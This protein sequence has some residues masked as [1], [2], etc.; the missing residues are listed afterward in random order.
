MDSYV[1]DIDLGTINTAAVVCCGGVFENVEMDNKKVLPSFVE[2]LNNN[3]T[4]VG[5][6]AQRSY[7]QRN[8][9]VVS[10]SKRI[11]GRKFNCKEVQDMKNYCGVEIVSRDNK[12]FFKIPSQNKE[13]SPEQIAKIILKKVIQCSYAQTQ[14]QLKGISVSIPAQFDNNQTTATIQAV[15][16]AIGELK[17]TMPISDGLQVF[18]LREPTAAAYRYF[19]DNQMTKSNILVYDFGGGTFDV[20]IIHIENKEVTVLKTRGNNHLGGNDIDACI[21][22]YYLQKYKEIFKVDCIPDDF[23]D[24]KKQAMYRQIMSTVEQTKRVLSESKET[25]VEFIN[26]NDLVDDDDSE[27]ETTYSF[28]LKRDEFD[29]LIKSVIQQ[30]VQCVYDCL[31]DAHLA[32]NDIDMVVLAGGS[33]NIKL[34]NTIISGIFGENKIRHTVDTALCVA[35]GGCRWLYDQYENQSKTNDVTPY[36]LET[37]IKGERT[38]CIIPKGVPIPCEYKQNFT[39]DYDYEPIIQSSLV[40]GNSMIA[41][42]INPIEKGVIIGKYEYDGFRNGRVNDVS[43]TETYS[44]NEHGVV[45]IRVVERET[46]K[47]LFDRDINW[48]DVK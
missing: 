3:T 35:E 33:S 7:R 44:Y 19:Y 15:K 41:G 38:S 23:P 16:D 42:E 27:E 25:E 20:S 18:T 47:V 30:T 40:Q 9:C 21:C 46:N 14:K 2:F 26:M 43:F 32:V 45:H 22:N 28:T 29:A 5:Y 4:N 39:L 24:E 11:I 17:D 31:E 8:K 13:V 12:P 36:S 1:L 48:N 6:S 10:N 34:V 37:S